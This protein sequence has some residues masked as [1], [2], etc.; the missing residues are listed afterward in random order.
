MLA[1]LW[2][3]L[4]DPANRAVLEWIGG[5]VVVVAGG[6]WAVVK[7][8]AKKS[9]GGSSPGVRADNGSVAIGG[10]NTNSPISIGPPRSGKR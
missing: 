2:T 9:D 8:F 10:S 4:K 5:G 1:D 3:F 7:F 6:W